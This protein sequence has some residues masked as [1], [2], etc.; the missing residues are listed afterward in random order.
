MI[1]NTIYYKHNRLHLTFIHQMAFCEQL[2]YRV[3][4]EDLQISCFCHLRYF[5]QYLNFFCRVILWWYD[6][7]Y[8]IRL[9]TKLRYSTQKFIEKTLNLQCFH[10]YSILQLFTK[11]Y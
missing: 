1:T 5:V 4:K 6:K 7:H 10:S 2:K 9:K 3:A 11:R 8:D